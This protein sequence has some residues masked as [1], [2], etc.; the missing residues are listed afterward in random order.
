VSTIRLRPLHSGLPSVQ[1]LPTVYNDGFRARAGTDNLTLFSRGTF[2][3]SLSPA[4]CIASFNT[5]VPPGSGVLYDIAGRR[6]RQDGPRPQLTITGPP[7]LL[8]R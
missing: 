3:D 8:E 1:V 7:L 6:L 4:A 2:R 5:I